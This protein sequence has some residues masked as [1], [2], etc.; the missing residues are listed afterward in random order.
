MSNPYVAHDPAAPSAQ[1]SSAK[2]LATVVYALQAA[3]I[4]IGVTLFVAVI[5]NYVKRDEAR[6]TWVESH[7][8]WQIRTF[9]LSLLFGLLLGLV[10]VVLAVGTAGAASIGSDVGTA[11]GALSLGLAGI[12]GGLAIFAWFVYRVI[13]GWLRLNNNQPI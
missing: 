11:G 2:G 13:K 6:G 4:I 5:I 1:V 9:W 12:V 7:F 3:S 10:M 8:R